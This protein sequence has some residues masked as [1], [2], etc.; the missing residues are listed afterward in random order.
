MSD[1]VSDQAGTAGKGGSGGVAE[2][3]AQTALAVMSHATPFVSPQALAAELPLAH[4][5]GIGT[6]EPEIMQGHHHRDPA[7]A[8]LREDGGRNERE[9]VVDVNDVGVLGVEEAGEGA[10]GERIVDTGEKGLKVPESLLRNLGAAAGK[11]D[12]L[13]SLLAQQLGQAAHD[14]LFAA[15][16]AVVVMNYGDFQWVD[17]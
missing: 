14:R 17:S 12:S 8:T 11:P 4:E 13:V 6:K 16:L 3:F 7:S 2:A 10:A 15:G 9:E 5:Q 1:V